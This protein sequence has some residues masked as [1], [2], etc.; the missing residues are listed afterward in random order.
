MQM[1]AQKRRK[2]LKAKKSR[3]GDLA[4]ISFPA[5]NPDKF[6]TW[7][8][9][10]TSFIYTW[11]FTVLTLVLFAIMAGITIATLGPNRPGHAALLQF[12]SKELGGRRDLLR[13]RCY[14]NVLA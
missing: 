14:I 4:Q 9:R 2:L 6:L 11:W 12:L 1:D 10:H 8:Y 3:W 13:G 7:L 5:V